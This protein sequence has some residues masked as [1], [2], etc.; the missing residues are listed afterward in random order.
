[1]A[2]EKLTQQALEGFQ[3]QLKGIQDEDLVAVS[4]AARDKFEAM[5]QG[6]IGGGGL[7]DPTTGTQSSRQPQLDG[8][9]QNEG[10]DWFG[11]YL[12]FV[13]LGFPWRVAAYIAWASSPKVKRW[14]KSQDALARQVLGLTSDR[15]IIKWRQ[16]NPNIDRMIVQLQSQ[17]LFEHRADIFDALIESATTPNYKNHQDRKLAL[18][19]TGDYN[20]KLQLVDRRSADSKDLSEKSDDEL[21]ELAAAA[22]RGKDVWDKPQ[23]DERSQG[24]EE[25][26]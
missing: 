11:Q 14:P 20:P 24:E 25:E 17:P 13:K 9:E 21:R 19:I 12:D 5:I 26:V 7:G 6:M 10:N 22:L 8:N 23:L 2:V 1:M 16:N 4:S 3:D 18:E 15:V